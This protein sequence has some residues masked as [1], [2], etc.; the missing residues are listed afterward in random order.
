MPVA[1]V[2]FDRALPQALAAIFPQCLEQS[3]ASSAVSLLYY[4]EI[5]VR[6]RRE[7]FEHIP[8]ADPIAATDSN[9]R[10]QSPATREHREPAKQTC[11]TVFSKSSAP[12]Y[13]RPQRLLSRKRGARASGEQAEPVVEPAIDFFD[14]HRP[15]PRDRELDRRRDAIEATAN[16]PDC[17]R[18]LGRDC[19][20][21]NLRLRARCEK[22]YCLER[23][24]MLGTGTRLRIRSRK[25]RNAV[26]HLA[27]HAEPFTAAH[28]QLHVATAPQHEVDQLRTRI[29]QVLR[30]VEH[31]Q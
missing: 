12:I 14:R 21:C 30:V 19:E 24:Q 25:G 15:Q 1:P 16:R 17:G 18:V 4:H 22:A 6:Q 2:L 11:S 27:W 29:E 23:R 8:L 28:E 3:V 31:E 26:Y 5:L 20:L 9:G 13:Q 10:L 7:Q